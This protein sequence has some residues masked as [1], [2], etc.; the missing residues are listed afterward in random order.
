MIEVIVKG[1]QHKDVKGK[2]EVTPIEKKIVLNYDVVKY[3]IPLGNETEAVFL[4][5]ERFIIKGNASDLHNQIKAD[6]K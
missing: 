4:D 3:L 6:K 2:K 5:G 1:Q